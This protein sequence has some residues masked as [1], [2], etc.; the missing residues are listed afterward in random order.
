MISKRSIIF[1]LFRVR[2]KEQSPVK[3]KILCLKSSVFW[4]KEIN[5]TKIYFPF[6]FP[7]INLWEVQRFSQAFQNSPVNAVLISRDTTLALV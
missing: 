7:G 4:R 6:I 5:K 2:L 1:R 3:S